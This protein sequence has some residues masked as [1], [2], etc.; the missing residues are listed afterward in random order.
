M[1]FPIVSLFFISYPYFWIALRALYIVACPSFFS[2]T[3]CFSYLASILTSLTFWLTALIMITTPKKMSPFIICLLIILFIAFSSSNLI[4]FYFFFE[5]SLIPTLIIVLGWGTQPERIQASFYLLIYTVSRRLPLLISMIYIFYNRGHLSSL[6]PN[7]FPSLWITIILAFLVKIPMYGVHLWLPKAHVE[8]PVAGSIILA[9]ILLKL[10][11]Y[12]MI[13]FSSLSPPASFF[14]SSFLMASSMWGAIVT[15][16][17]CLRQTDIKALI[18]YSSV[19][20]IALVIGGILSNTS[21]G[22]KGATIIMVA[23]GLS[24]PALFYIAN[25]VYS[26]SGSR[27]LILNKGAFNAVSPFIIMWCFLFSAANMAAPPFI[28]LPREIILLTRILSQSIFL[29]SIIVVVSFLAGAYSMFLFSSLSH[30]RPVSC[31]TLKPLPSK[32][33]SV[34]FFHF[35][36]LAL[37]TLKLS[38]FI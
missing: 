31:S 19:G 23:H 38:V 9:G 3:F 14:F 22:W 20:H 21:W 5:A 25:S 30:G 1:L 17:L 15:S 7:Y 29:A 26:S 27:A 13:L 24:S 10:G 12:G 32:D 6:M 33:F 18:A 35:C 34:L 4:V 36:P 28:R 2:Y 11:G 16:A 37:L 8:A